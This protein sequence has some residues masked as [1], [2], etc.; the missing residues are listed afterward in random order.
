MATHPSTSTI[1]SSTPRLDG[2][3][4]LVTGAGRGIGKAIALAFAVAGA[5]S[6]FV[7]RDRGLGEQLVAEYEAKGLRVDL[8]VADV[9]DA[10]QIAM[11]AFDLTQRYPTIDVLVNNA[12]V[13]LDEDRSGPPSR[14]DPIVL[15]RTLHV[16]LFG[17]VRMCDAFIPHIAD[18]GRIINVS[19]R[20]GQFA[21]EPQARG[22]AYCIS[23]SALNMYT[24]MLAV[25]LRPRKIMA[26]CFHPGWAKTDMGGPRATIEPEESAR[27]ALFLATRPYSEETGL[28]WQDMTPL[29]W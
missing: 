2:K 25:D 22:P 3:T 19:S 8:G 26:D 17:P 7:V 27:T 6:I 14:L 13:F 21:G 1:T 18:G 11:L 5:Q 20:M 15:E 16:N 28:F 4:T 23:K 24:Q 9:C 29:E 12:G 10:G